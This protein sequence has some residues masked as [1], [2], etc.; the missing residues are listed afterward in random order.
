MQAMAEAHAHADGLT[1]QTSSATDRRAT[2]PASKLLDGAMLAMFIVVCIAA[3]GVG[4]VFT[5]DSVAGWYRTI[6]KP[7]W[8]PPDRVFGPVWTVLFISMGVAAWLVWRRGWARCRGALGLFGIQLLLNVGWS[9]VFFGLRSPGWA[10]VEI[11]CLWIALVVTIAM[12]WRHSRLAAVLL[13]PYLGWSTFAAVLNLAIWRANIP[14]KADDA[15]A[16][17][18]TSLVQVDSAWQVARMPSEPDVTC[19]I[20]LTESRACPDEVVTPRDQVVPSP[21]GPT[22]KARAKPVDKPDVITPAKEY[23]RALVALAPK[24]PAG[25]ERFETFVQAA[26][27]LARERSATGDPVLENRAALVALGALLGDSRV[28]GFQRGVVDE[29]Q[30]TAAARVAGQ[31]TIRGRRDWTQHFCVSAAITTTSNE[32]A[33]N[34]IGLMKERMDMRPGGSGFSFADLAA[35]RA[36]T[37][38]AVAATRDEAAARAMQDRLAGKFALDDLFPRADDLPEGLSEAALKSRYGGVGGPGYKE[39]M[40]EIEQRLDGCAALEQ[41]RN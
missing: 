18:G 32:A 28:G 26:F 30:R 9:L 31:V 2:R 17:Q 29:A 1:M 41:S 16:R 23:Y 25:D 5:A 15:S 14:A 36:G 6:A 3:G 39:L 4:A 19:G 8:T 40:A 11:L 12:F 7:S 37:R 10:F 27:R 24:L 20:E 33:S 38:L 13:L 35:D 21:S 34:H 22:T